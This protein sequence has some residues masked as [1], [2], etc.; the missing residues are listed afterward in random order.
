MT[1]EDIVLSRLIVR[2]WLWVR[3]GTRL[4]GGIAMRI[5]EELWRGTGARVPD[6]GGDGTAAVSVMSGG[7]VP[8]MPACKRRSML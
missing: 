1:R 2:D 5:V 4:P 7:T 6:G 3:R 8:R